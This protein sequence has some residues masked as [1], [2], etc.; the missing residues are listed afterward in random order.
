[1]YNMGSCV[2]YE[3]SDIILLWEFLLSSFVK[4][5]CC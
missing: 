3:T 5:D 4:N 2:Y 1:M